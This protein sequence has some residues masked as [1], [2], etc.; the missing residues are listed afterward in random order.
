MKRVLRGIPK[1]EPYAWLFFG[2]R[3]EN[4]EISKVEK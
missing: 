1:K 4:G 3:Y 2:K